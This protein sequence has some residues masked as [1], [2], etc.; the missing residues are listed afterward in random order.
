VIAATLMIRLEA[1]LTQAAKVV[2]PCASFRDGGDQTLNRD[3]CFAK[4]YR[5][6]NGTWR[7]VS[8]KIVSRP[9]DIP[10]GW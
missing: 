8:K 4:T 5:L 9:L 10:G 3:A 2:V 7:G 1:G 6:L